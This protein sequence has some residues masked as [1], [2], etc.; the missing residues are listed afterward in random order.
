M[1]SQG[2]NNG[3]TFANDTTVGTVDWDTPGNAQY[4]DYEYAIAT[5]N[6]NIISHYLKATGFGFSIPAGSI[7]DGIQVD[8]QRHG[9]DG[10]FKDYSVKIV[11]G[12]TIQGDEKAPADYWPTEDAYKT[13]G[14]PADLWGLSWAVSDINGPDF[15]VVI[16]AKNFSN[17]SYAYIDHIRI[18]IYFTEAPAASSPLVVLWLSE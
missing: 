14:G 10:T 15:G 5:L 16:S 12:G 8:C 13:Y 1:N 3:N 11:K 9:L 17:E 6:I 2:P 7:I 18:T 4:S